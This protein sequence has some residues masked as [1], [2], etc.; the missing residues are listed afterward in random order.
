VSS[1]PS[2]SQFDTTLQNSAR[3]DFKILARSEPANR[4]NLVDKLYDVVRPPRPRAGRR[5]KSHRTPLIA[6]R[7]FEDEADPPKLVV[8][9]RYSCVVEL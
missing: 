8:P 5:V 2:L 9:P 6:P 3:L 1:L 7:I 4:S